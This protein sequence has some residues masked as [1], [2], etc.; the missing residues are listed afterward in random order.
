MQ[1]KRKRKRKETQTQP[2]AQS[3][4]TRLPSPSPL[5]PTS[6]AQPE[7]A[8]PAAR[9]SFPLL[10]HVLACF[11]PLRA[12]V[13]VTVSSPQHTRTS[14]SLTTWSHPTELSPSYAAIF[15]GPPLLSGPLPLRASPPAAGPA[16]PCALAFQKPRQLSR[17][18]LLEA[19]PGIRSALLYPASTAKSSRHNS[20]DSHAE[21][22]PHR[23]INAPYTSPNPTPP[24]FPLES[25]ATPPH[26]EFLADAPRRQP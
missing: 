17:T 21:D 10:S 18:L 6:P 19:K 24:Q 22:P 16:T 2:S 14:R 1:K 5:R 13:R 12:S 23:L 3:S 25:S 4:P 20:R 7:P 15:A 11:P 9:P 8:Q 26:G